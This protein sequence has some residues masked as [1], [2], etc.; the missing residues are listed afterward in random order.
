MPCNSSYQ[1]PTHLEVNTAKVCALLE[2]VKTGNLPNWYGNGSHSSAY[3]CSS[4]HRLDNITAQL[5]SKLQNV[6]VTKFSL[7]LQIWWRDHQEADTRRLKRE[8]QECKDRDAAISKLTPYE[9]NLLGI[10]E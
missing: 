5:C 6:N 4:D 8:I 9:R 7:E 1:D 2:E 10:A 3:N